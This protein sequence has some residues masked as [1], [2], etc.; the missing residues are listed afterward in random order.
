MDKDSKQYFEILLSKI[1]TLATE[2]AE[3]RADVSGIKS[4]LTETR[5]DVSGIK[6][7]LAETRAELTE[8]RTDVS[9]IKNEVTKTNLIIE[10]E[11]RPTMRLLA[12][13][14]ADIKEVKASLHDLGEKVEDIAISVSVLK[15]VVPEHGRQ[16]KELKKHA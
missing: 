10:N 14:Q 6:S 4:E 13:G 16:L 12:E 9:S 5:A 15:E 8:T 1:D 3:T 2:V 11:I 7:E